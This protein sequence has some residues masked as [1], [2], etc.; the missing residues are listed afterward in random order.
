MNEFQNFCISQLGDIYIYKGIG[1]QKKERILLEIFERKVF[2][3]KELLCSD[4]PPT[5]KERCPNCFIS[6]LVKEVTLGLLSKYDSSVAGVTPTK[7]GKRVR[8]CYFVEYPRERA[9]T[10]NQPTSATRSEQEM[11]RYFQQID[12]GHRKK[13]RTILARFMLVL[14]QLGHHQGCRNPS[15]KKTK[16]RGALYF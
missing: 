14:V 12:G 2:L 9:G 5:L 1:K 6:L 16:L 15:S 8:E 7:D 10:H 3:Q 11:R 4:S 13:R